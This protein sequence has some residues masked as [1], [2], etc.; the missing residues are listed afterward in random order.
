MSIGSSHALIEGRDQRV[1]DGEAAAV[2]ALPALDLFWC[3]LRGLETRAR[4]DKE[5]A[6]PLLGGSA[7]PLLPLFELL[8][9][10]HSLRWT[11]FFSA[12]FSC[13]KMTLKRRTSRKF[14][15]HLNKW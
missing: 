10:H 1:A 11:V 14:T 13:Q 2:P 6:G 4:E 3:A 9:S 5:A 7:R 8:W 15:G 12:T